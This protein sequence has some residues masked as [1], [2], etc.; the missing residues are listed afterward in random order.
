MGVWF[1]DG[2]RRPGNPYNISQVFSQET[3]P[4]TSEQAEICVA[5]LALKQWF[6]AR[7][8]NKLPQTQAIILKSASA[9]LVASMIAWV[10]MWKTDGW[11]T[12][13]GGT[14]IN[15]DLWE[16]L[17]A[18]VTAIETSGVRVWFWQVSRECNKL[19]VALAW[20][21]WENETSEVKYKSLDTARKQYF[22]VDLLI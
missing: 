10:P 4:T 2:E 12:S 15:K 18:M 21:A 5:I 8:D 16:Q 9:Y 22:K 1:G 7:V 13:D 19:A 11:K 17:D 3:A 20:D 14:V 6:Q